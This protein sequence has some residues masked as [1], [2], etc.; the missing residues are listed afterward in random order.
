MSTPEAKV[1][2]PVVAWAEKAGFLHKRCHYG[3]GENAWPDDIFIAPGGIHVWTE[4]KAPGKHP[5]ALQQHRLNMLGKQGAMAFW[6]DNAREGIA[7][8]QRV[9]NMAAVLNADLDVEAARAKRG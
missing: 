4:F 7:A 9:L 1:R 3:A 6:C 5:T 8:L 2:D